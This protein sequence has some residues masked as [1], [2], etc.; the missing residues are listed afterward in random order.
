MIIAEFNVLKLWGGGRKK[1]RTKR[2]CISLLVE[3]I[4][5]I[6]DLRIQ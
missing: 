4:I 1:E 2:E 5:A 6:I 3:K